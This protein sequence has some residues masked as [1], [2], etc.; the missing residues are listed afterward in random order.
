MEEELKLFNFRG[1]GIRIID[2]EGSPWFVAKDVAS[3]LE[4]TGTEAMTRR[5]DDD[6]RD[7]YTDKSSG[8]NRTC[9]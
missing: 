9:K 3:I 4:Y 1:N 2:R 8:Q 7:S 6:A 5:L